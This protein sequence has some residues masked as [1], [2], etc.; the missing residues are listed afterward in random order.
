MVTE[1]SREILMKNTRLITAF[2]VAA[3]GP[4]A[5]AIAESDQANATCGKTDSGTELATPACRTIEQLTVALADIQRL[6]PDGEGHKDRAF[7]HARAA[8][9]EVQSYTPPMVMAT[10]DADPAPPR[11]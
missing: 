7:E 11:Q 5:P 4:V 3:L 6:Q 8:L 10:P 9:E 2:L 1:S